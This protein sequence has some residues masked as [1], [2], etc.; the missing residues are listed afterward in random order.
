M[1]LLKKYRDLIW[2]A[3]IILLILFWFKGCFGG[4]G[5]GETKIDTVY[6]TDTILVPVQGEKIEIPVIKEVY[7]PKPVKTEV[8]VPVYI[9]PDTAAILKDYYATKIYSEKYPTQYGDITIADTVS[10]NVIKG[11]GLRYKFEVPVVTTQMTITKEQPKRN[12]VYVGAGVWGSPESWLYGTE[13]SLSLKNK[14]DKIYSVKGMLVNGGQAV[15]G[16]GVS[17]PIRLKKR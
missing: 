10:E 7:Y 3:V 13:V 4:N 15:Y 5:S 2:L 1:N 12:V 16:V 8:E 17:V 14:K 6:S 11:R 9:Q